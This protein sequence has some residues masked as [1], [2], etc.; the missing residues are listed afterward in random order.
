MFMLYGKQYVLGFGILA[1]TNPFC[2]DSGG[3]EVFDIT[4]YWN[5]LGI[6]R[7]Y[8]NISLALLKAACNNNFGTY[9]MGSGSQRSFCNLCGYLEFRDCKFFGCIAVDVSLFLQI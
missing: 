9:D 4:E 8:Q 6:G 7:A 3:A 5:V 1:D 2:C